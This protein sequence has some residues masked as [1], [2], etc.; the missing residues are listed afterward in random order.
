[1][2]SSYVCR[3]CRAR[4]VPRAASLRNP[5]WQPRATFISLRNEQ[6]APHEAQDTPQDESAP[7]KSEDATSVSSTIRRVEI[8]P[9]R[10][11]ARDALR[12][13][14]WG[15][16]K[17]SLGTGRYSRYAQ[18]TEALGKGHPRES[19]EGQS[20]LGR[21][22]KFPSVTE[23]VPNYPESAAPREPNSTRQETPESHAVIIQKYLRE[24]DLNRAWESFLR[25]YTSRDSAAYSNPSFQ[26]VRLLNLSLIHI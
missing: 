13:P 22:E 11:P 18:N 2:I 23:H 19:L 3:Q 20:R 7:K 8:D 21:T 25:N 24:G 4:L 16:R 17:P 1:M 9:P 10:D 12:E 26:D 15:A 6:A 14:R 5:Q